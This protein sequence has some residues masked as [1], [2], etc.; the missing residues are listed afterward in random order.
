M[1]TFNVPVLIGGQATGNP[2]TD[3]RGYA[4]ATKVIRVSA[5]NKRVGFTVP[6]GTTAL[7]ATVSV[8]SAATLGQGAVG[9]FGTNSNKTLY[10]S[11]NALATE[12]I[13]TVGLARY[14]SSMGDQMAYVEVSASVAASA[15]DFTGGKFDWR[16]TYVTVV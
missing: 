13:Y 9:Y 5:N 12:A 15:G 3:N 2:T 4:T 1:T 11:V 6:P 7:M 10:G 14:S 16:I 8:V